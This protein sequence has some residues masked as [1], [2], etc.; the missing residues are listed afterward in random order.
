MNERHVLASDHLGRLLVRLSLPAMIGMLVMGLYN[1]VDTIFV[2]R[3][4]GTLAIAGIA[5]AFPIQIVVM[6]VSQML[7][8]GAASVVSRSLGAGRP[9]RAEAA[10]GCMLLAAAAY[11][12]VHIAAGYIFLDPLLR[13]FGAT[14][15]ILPHARTYMRILLLG[16]L[17]QTFAM[18]ANNIIRAEGQARIAMVSMISGAVANIILDPI[19]IFGLDL[20]LAGAAWA[21]VLAKLVQ[22]GYVTWY[23]TSGRSR[24]SL[25]PRRLRFAASILREILAVGSASFVRMIT[26]SVLAVV[27]NHTL[28]L[29]GGDTAIAAY[30][31]INRFLM[32]TFTPLMGLAQGLQPIAGFNWGARRYDKTRRAVRLAG[33]AATAIASA[34]GLLLVLL[35]R[36]AIAI[37]TR[38]P[39]LL[40][41]GTRALRIMVL[42]LPV[43]GF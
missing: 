31:V 14:A 7:G 41:M 37:F 26:G 34:A 6:A 36:P 24:L 10:F 20:G 27:M 12:T 5:V 32:F 16:T 18:S 43:V 17:F 38:D 39:A 2:G 28:G 19:L 13:A 25:D 11:G 8:I 21:T 23:F 1:V 35:P 29:H 30:G 15:G 22:A 9:D 42:A 33:L 4:V 3:G 40:A